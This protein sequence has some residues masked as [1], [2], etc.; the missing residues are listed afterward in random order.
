[1]N[2]TGLGARARSA[3]ARAMAAAVFFGASGVP[4]A[5]A[6]EALVR[7]LM[8]SEGASA[9]PEEEPAAAVV[10]LFLLT[11]VVLGGMRAEPRPEAF[12]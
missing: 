8:A 11:M 6:D 1:M 4:S 9:T 5:I 10:L 12:Y 3:L 7:S 2:R